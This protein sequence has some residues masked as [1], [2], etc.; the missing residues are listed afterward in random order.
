MPHLR[1]HTFAPFQ[2]LLQDIDAALSAAL[3]VRG[4]DSSMTLEPRPT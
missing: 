1:T 4:G 2:G 3:S